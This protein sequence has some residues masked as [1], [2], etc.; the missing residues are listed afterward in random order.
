MDNTLIETKKKINESEKIL[1]IFNNTLTEEHL[2]SALGLYLFLKEKGKKVDIISSQKHS[3]TNDHLDF[4]EPYKYINKIEFNEN[5][6]ICI[7]IPKKELKKIKYDI[8]DDQLKFIIKHT[9]TNLSSSD[10]IANR[11]NDYD[12]IICI[13]IHNYSNIDLIYKKYTNLF[14]TKP[15]I[16]IDYD[17][18]NANYANINYVDTNANSTAE[19]IHKIIGDDSLNNDI[20]T[21]LLSSIIIK[22]N[23][24]KT[25]SMNAKILEFSSNLIDKGAKKEEVVKNL[26]ASREINDIKSWG[27]ILSNL[28]SDY[29]DRLVWFTINQNDFLKFSKTIESTII[30]LVNELIHTIQGLQLII[31]FYESEEDTKKLA[32]ALIFSNSDISIE[33]ITENYRHVKN[34]EI[35][36]INSEENINDFK[37]NILNRAKNLM[38]KN[39]KNNIESLIMK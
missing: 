20:S 18:G 9:S 7:N 5:F 30:E 26:F 21:C 10:V 25:N 12:L 17:A 39:T 31:A 37:L 4:L 1:L 35:T 38:E 27:Q 13:G 32:N 33:S 22:T 11:D 23:H 14:N 3:P 16:N 19:L 29:E 36:L 24:F 2:C 15:V 8:Q 28:K 34:S 6:T